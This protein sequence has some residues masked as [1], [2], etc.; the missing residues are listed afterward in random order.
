MAEVRRWSVAPV[1]K[2]KGMG[3]KGGPAAEEVVHRGHSAAPTNKEEVLGAWDLRGKDSSN[4]VG[5]NVEVVSYCL[6]RWC[7]L[8]R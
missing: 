8:S 5:S 7:W 3:F 6:L 1:G 4:D 2:S